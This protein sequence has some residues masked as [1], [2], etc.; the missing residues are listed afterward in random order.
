MDKDIYDSN[1][2]LNIPV[3]VIPLENYHLYIEYEDGKTIDFDMNNY[4]NHPL[5]KLL[6]EK[7][8]FDLVQIKGSSI[9]WPND[10]DICADSL[11]EL[12]SK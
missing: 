4:L 7:A 1:V 3:K 9:S 11:Y 5:F 8:F 2:K 10:I 12:T 6:K